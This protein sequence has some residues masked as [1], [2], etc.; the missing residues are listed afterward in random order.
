M[1]INSNPSPI[2]V[3]FYLVLTTLFWGGSFLFTKIGLATIPPIHFV[4][5]RFGLAT[6][7]MFIIAS[8]RLKKLNRQTIRRGATVGLALGITNLVFVF[9]VS[10]TTISRAGILNNLFVLFIPLLAK[11]IWRDRIGGANIV[12]I[13]MAVWGII[14]LAGGGSGFNKGD[15]FS[16]LCAFFIAVHILTVSK[17]LTGNDDIYLISLVQF[18][19]V[20]I[21]AGLLAL[22]VPQPQYQLSGKA[23]GSIIYCAILPTVFCFTLQNAFQRYTTA[24]RAGLIYTLDPVWSLLAGFFILGER[25]S[26]GEIAGCGLLFAAVLTPLVLRFI[27]ERRQIKNRPPQ[28]D[29]T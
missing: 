29:S 8:G 20:A 28:W 11:F 1:A 25:L 6:L 2:R 16:T 18:F 24:T 5:M 23:L 13:I 14:L 9:G 12:G 7:I 26:V 3:D 17:V 22:I 19:V 10:G 21:L 4:A 15:M 27:Q